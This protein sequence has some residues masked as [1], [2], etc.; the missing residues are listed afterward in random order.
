MA[1]GRDRRY[2]GVKELLWEHWIY[3]LRKISR[4][5]SFLGICPLVICK[6]Y[7]S[8]IAIRFHLKLKFFVL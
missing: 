5:V 1:G 7:W 4:R 2:Q 3:V 8:G 6:P